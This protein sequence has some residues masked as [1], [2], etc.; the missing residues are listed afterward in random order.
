[1]S[2]AGLFD[3]SNGELRTV[4][5]SSI[6]EDKLNEICNST[7]KEIE[8]LKYEIYKLTGILKEKMYGTHDKKKSKNKSRKRL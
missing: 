5:E 4:D 7:R 1:M 2:T 3:I 8:R 6:F